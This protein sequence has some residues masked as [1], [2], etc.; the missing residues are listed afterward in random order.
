MFVAS[1][2]S[3]FHSRE[4][5]SDDGG[6]GRI[7]SKLSVKMNERL[8][9]SVEITRHAWET[10]KPKQPGVCCFLNSR[11]CSVFEL[12]RNFGGRERMNMF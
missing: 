11:V 3:S 12:D 1:N 4:K 9:A 10:D 2:E 8:V 5:G 7:P 6:D